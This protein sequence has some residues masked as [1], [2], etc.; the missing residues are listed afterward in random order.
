MAAGKEVLP[1]QADRANRT[2]GTMEL[3]R[4]FCSAARTRHGREQALVNRTPLPDRKN[5]WWSP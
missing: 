3:R 2:T 1:K 4:A 5:F